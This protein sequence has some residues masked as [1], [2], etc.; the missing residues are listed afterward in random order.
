MAE[1]LGSTELGD[2]HENTIIKFFINRI[3][4]LQSKITNVQEKNKHFKSEVKAI[5]ESLGFQNETYEKMKKDMM[6]EKEKLK[7]NYR[8]S[9]K[10]Q[11]LIQQNTEIKEQI[12]ELEDR[13][14]I[15]Y[16]LWTS[17]RNLE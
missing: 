12:P 11:N 1:S 14:R 5:Q 2:I 16:N 10:M 17:R 13:H 9:K 4:N 15:I 7:S 6:E 3:E 8:N